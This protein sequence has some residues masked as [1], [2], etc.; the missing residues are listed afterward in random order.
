VSHHHGVGR[1]KKAFMAREHGGALVAL[2]A[3]GA[4]L[5]P[6]GLM[7]PGA[8]LP[9]A[10]AGAAEAARGVA[11]E[12]EPEPSTAAAA[13]VLRAAR[14]ALAEAR[15]VVP[16]GAGTARPRRTPPPGAVVVT[17]A[18][19]TPEVVLDPVAG[20]VRAGAG[21]RIAALEAQLR[22]QGWTVRPWHGAMAAPGTIGG[23]LARA[24]AWR[25]PS[26]DGPSAERPVA[27]CALL[28]DGTLFRTPRTPRRA[29]GPEPAAALLGA[30]GRTGLLLEVELRAEPLPEASEEAHWRLPEREAL[31]AA[32]ALWRAAAATPAWYEDGALFVRFEGARGLVDAW[33]EAARGLLGPPAAREAPSGAWTGSAP[34]ATAPA[35]APARATQARFEVR[36]PWA[37]L[38]AAAEAARGCVAEALADDAGAGEIRLFHFGHEGG[39]VLVRA[40]AAHAA[41][42]AAALRARFPRPDTLAA[43]DDALAAALAAPR[44]A[45]AAGAEPPA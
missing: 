35:P 15:T 5:D 44:G 3:L 17:T 27:L 8:L 43:L 14:A 23:A 7:N 28:P 2:R 19:E 36:A 40:P 25:V 11:P 20:T 45:F 29:A 9:A 34:G 37:E 1:A 32:R 13:S 6:R 30:Y 22:P 21:A 10:G 38:G 18:E 4:A 42:L 16:A 41:A 12:A 24:L 31:D 26:L 33:T 39:R